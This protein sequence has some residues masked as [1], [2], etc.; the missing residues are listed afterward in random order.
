M[1]ENGREK[2]RKRKERERVRERVRMGELERGS[3]NA[4]EF[5]REKE[6]I[7]RWGKESESKRIR[8]EFEREGNL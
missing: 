3:E 8:G 7:S 2:F 4:K 1:R 6:E 5:Y